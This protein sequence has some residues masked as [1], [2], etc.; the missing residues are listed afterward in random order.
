MVG[1]GNAGIETEAKPAGS[2]VEWNEC[3]EV[4]YFIFICKCICI[5]LCDP[6]AYA[7]KLNSAIALHS[8]RFAYMIR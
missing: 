4:Y 1:E 2:M 7:S 5:I 8:T 6:N 3:E